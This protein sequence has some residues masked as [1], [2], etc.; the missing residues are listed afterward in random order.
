MKIGINDVNLDMMKNF[1]FFSVAAGLVITAMVMASC[2]EAGLSPSP[3]EGAVPSFKTASMRL[4]GAMPSYDT[5]TRADETEGEWAD[6]S[7]VYLQFAVGEEMV[8]GSATYDLLEDIWTLEYAG[9]L[10]TVESAACQAYYFENA[11]KATFEE[12]PM[13][14][15]TAVY[16]DTTATYSF[17]F[18]DNLIVLKAHLKPYLSRVRLEG[19]HKQG[20]NFDGPLHYASYNM[21]ENKFV[22]STKMICDTI[23]ESGKTDYYYLFFKDQ[24]NKQ[25]FFYDYVTGDKFTRTFPENVFAMGKSGYL[26][27]PTAEAYSGWEAE[28]L[29]IDVKV[30]NETVRMI[31]VEPGTFMMGMVTTTESSSMPVHQVTL[32]KPYYI[33]ETEVT[34]AVWYAVQ[35]S[36]PSKYTGSSRPVQ[37]VSWDDCSKFITNLNK[38]TGKKF[39]LPTEAQWEFAARGGNMSKGYKYYSGSDSYKDVAVFDRDM[40]GTTSNSTNTSLL[41]YGPYNVKS[42]KPNELGIYDMSGNVLEWCSDWYGTYSSSAQTDPTGPSSNIDNDKVC[43]GGD[44]YHKFYMTNRKDFYWKSYIYDTYGVT[45]L[46][47]VMEP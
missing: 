9:T 34:N 17:S 35:G 1:R 33:S 24:D 41:T 46:R 38:H 45:G 28:K 2:D 7:K 39:S 27:A 4:E 15:K 26:N 42:K 18:E 3:E 14:E 25:M 43:R 29:Y 8:S 44:W 31:R 19:K 30:Y 16:I 37:N 21:L 10:Q 5:A 36:N 23:P 32:T 40:Y 11:G 12:V 47:L 6:K 13:T 22:S 20:Y